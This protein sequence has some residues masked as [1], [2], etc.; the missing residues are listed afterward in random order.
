M[1]D[2]DSSKLVEQFQLYQQQYQTI[3]IQKEQLRLQQLESEKALEE[4]EA[5]KTQ[6]AYKITGTIM[7]KKDTEDL[8]KE[9][10]EKKEDIELRLKTLTKAEERVTN[11]LK[12]MEGDIRKL[13]EK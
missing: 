3:M 1:V 4:L 10:K 5:S 11:K 13:I 2:L 7:I 12:Q 6:K 8:K 9:L